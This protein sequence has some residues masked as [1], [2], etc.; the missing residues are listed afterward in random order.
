M[1][2]IKPDTL[3]LLDISSIY[4]HHYDDI[5]ILEYYGLDIKTLLWSLLDYIQL[6]ENDVNRYIKEYIIEDS[7]EMAIYYDEYKQI[8][9][10]DTY[11]PDYVTILEGIEV[12]KTIEG[13][14]DRLLDSLIA[15]LKPFFQRFPL[16]TW[17][18][19]YNTRHTLYIKHKHLSL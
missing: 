4:R 16:Q 2:F 14:L 13:C 19:E 11:K 17:Y 1:N 9:N 15:L 6:N 7:I 3:A 18:Y 8:V 12:I 10:S 5:L